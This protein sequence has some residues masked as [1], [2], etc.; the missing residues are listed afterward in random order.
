MNIWV[1]GC[2]DILHSGHLDLLQY[3]KDFKNDSTNTQNIL[4]VGIDSDR[5]VKELKGKMRPINSENERKRMLQSLKFVDMVVIF[6]SNEELK[7]N[8]KHWNIDYMV[9]GDQYKDKEVIGAEESKYGAIFYPVDDRSSTSIID[10]IL[11]I[12][13]SSNGR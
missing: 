2:F 3:A 4:I 7:Y 10:K 12:Y 13:D 8:I 5:R 1:N 11:K 6:G 9:V